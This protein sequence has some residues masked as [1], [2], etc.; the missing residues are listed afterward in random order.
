MSDTFS[1]NHI[2]HSGPPPSSVDTRPPVPAGAHPPL[3]E[4]PGVRRVLDLAALT[5]LSGAVAATTSLTVA[6]VGLLTAIGA[7][8]ALRRS[9]TAR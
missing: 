7:R 8:V 4:L 6:T 1:L 5:V 2:D 9:L 3:V